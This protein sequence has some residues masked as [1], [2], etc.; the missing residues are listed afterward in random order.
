MYISFCTTCMNRIEFLKQTIYTNLEIIKFFNEKYIDIHQF[1]LSLC[2]YDSND[3]LDEYVK[4]NLQEYIDNKLLVYTKSDNHE[5]FNPGHAKNI[6]HRYSNGDLLVNVDADN[7]LTFKFIEFL[8]GLFRNNKNI[9]TSGHV[10]EGDGSS[11][12]RIALTRNNFYKLGGYNENFKTYSYEDDD[13]LER[14]VE[15]L[16]LSLIRFPYDTLKYITH[17]NSKRVEN[18]TN[19]YYDFD[20][21]ENNRINKKISNYYINK[22]IMNPNEYEKIE[23]GKI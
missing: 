23:F 20:I 12:G 1:E 2:N 9:I 6:A 13:I 15:F 17:D 22:G 14:G 19:K 21:I 4:N 8:L 3:G 11:Y 10:I 7:I 5:Y 18:F 16:K